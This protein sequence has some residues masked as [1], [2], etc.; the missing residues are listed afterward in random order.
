MARAYEAERNP[1]ITEANKM[2]LAAAESN[3]KHKEQAKIVRARM[4]EQRLERLSRYF[5]ASLGGV[6]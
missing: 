2:A 1:E 5:A 3:Q 4:E 6:R